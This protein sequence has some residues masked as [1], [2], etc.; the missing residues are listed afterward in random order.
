MKKSKFD[1]YP[2]ELLVRRNGNGTRSPVLVLGITH[3]MML[4]YE[5]VL[6]YLMWDG[7]EPPYKVFALKGKQIEDSAYERQKR[8]A[9][10]TSSVVVLELAYS[11]R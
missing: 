2:G 3:E 11:V 10:C 4:H 1:F 7:D 9:S 8:G 6:T 5:T